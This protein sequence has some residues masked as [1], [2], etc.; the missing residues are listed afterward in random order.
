MKNVAWI[1]SDAGYAHTTPAGHVERPERLTAVKD[2]FANA[3]IDA[4]RIE[5]RKATREDLLRAHTEAHVA[6][7]EKT[8]A[9]SA[10][11][12]D[13]DTFMVPGSWDAALYAAGS[14]IA[15]CKAVLEGRADRVF[16]ALRPPGHHAETDR[17]MGF[18]LFNSAAVAARWLQAEAGIKRVAIL[19]W[20]VHHG[21]GTQNITYADAD[22][23]Y[24]SIHEWPNYPGTGL[25]EERGPHRTNLNI[26][27]AHGVTSDYW[28]EQIE[29]NVVPE[30]EAFQPDFFLI[31]AGFDAHERDPLSLQ[32]LAAEDFAEMTRRVRHLAGG[33]IVS[34]LEGGY[35]LQGLGESAAA[36]FQALQED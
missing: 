34:L 25:P 9:A 12:P 3:G 17:A 33:K 5:P 36:H 18:C 20:D 1:F 6:T 26:L 4:P 30:L 16:S 11:Y 14:V 23:Y 29:R 8:C 24:V 32:S 31:S 22:I 2:A 28:L 15:G 13:P 21:N 35:D 19:D 7:V 10:P 27:A